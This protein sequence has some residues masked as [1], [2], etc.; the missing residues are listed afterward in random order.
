MARI[1]LSDHMI[2]KFLGDMRS[3]QHRIDEEWRPRWNKV[4][5]AYQGKSPEEIHGVVGDRNA[6]NF[7]FI[8][9]TANTIIPSVLPTDP[10]ITFKSRDPKDRDAAFVAEASVNYAY[11]TGR[12]NSATRNVLL[13]CEKFSMGIGKVVYNPAG[14]VTPVIH[15]DQDAEIELDHDEDALDGAI[16]SEIAYEM[17]S[18]GFN[19]LI[20]GDGIDI[21]TLERVAPWNFLFPEGH[22]DINKCP[23]VAERL[24]VKL[25]DLRMYEGFT[26]KPHVMAKENL[27]LHL[28]GG[29]LE[30]AIM[31]QPGA[32]ID[33]GFVALYEIHYWVRQKRK[34]VRR[35]LWI[36]DNTNAQGFDRVV[37]HIEDDSGMRGYP[38]VMLRTVVNPG[39]MCEPDIADLATIQPVADR[40]NAELAAV[41]RHHKQASKQ[42]YVAAPGALSGDSQFEK[43]LRS[44]RDLSAAELPSQFND[45]R[46]ALQLVPI[47]PM[48]PDVPFMLQTLQRLMYEIGGVDV[49]QRGGVARKGT[50]ATEV[51][52]A[53][54][55][56][57][58]RAQIRKRAVEQFIEDVARRYLDCMRRYWTQT[59]W[60]RGAGTGDDSFIEVSSERMRGAFDITASVSEFDP[61]EQTNELQAFNGLLQTIAATIQTIMPLVQ[62]QVLPK[63]TINNFVRKAFEL[64][65]QDSRRLIGPLSSLANPIASQ[66][67]I[68]A[69]GPANPEQEMPSAGEDV[70]AASINGQGF[71]GGFQGMSGGLAGTGPRPGAGQIVEE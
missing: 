68:A 1:K 25:D 5:A 59:N 38:F 8:L 45:V 37:R 47:A 64:W 9:S 15:Y 65:R 67:N 58:N 16:G 48:P 39:K 28:P 36:L 51:A 40:L 49:F 18:E 26:V 41:L 52:V 56:F 32:D 7:N 43:L 71:G 42:K 4:E 11:K 31:R 66:Q 33:P 20:E 22:D 30:A 24:L 50:T 6:V 10:Y 55:S 61:N 34:L 14:N 35:I 12:A 13:D 54:Q 21:P 17:E 46:Q 2:D 29:T 3:S 60:I 63:D 62:A 19:M 44:E 69:Q 57:Q 53:S 70:Q 27:S 23:W